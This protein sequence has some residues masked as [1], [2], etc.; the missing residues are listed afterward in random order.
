MSKKELKD[1]SIGIRRSQPKDNYYIGAGD[2]VRI[3]ILDEIF[4]GYILEFG[5]RLQTNTEHNGLHPFLSLG[6]HANPK[7]N[8]FDGI[9]MLW[10]ENI[11]TLTV[12]SLA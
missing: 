7:D 6:K 12:V 2:Y 8:N 5:M 11:D 4:E 9:V 3:E 10:I 1:Q